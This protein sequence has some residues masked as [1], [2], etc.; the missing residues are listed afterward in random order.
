MCLQPRCH[1]VWSSEGSQEKSLRP[2]QKAMLHT[3]SPPPQHPR[4]ASQP[5]DQVSRIQPMGDRQ[6]HF[7]EMLLKMLLPLP[8]LGGFLMLFSKPIQLLV[9]NGSSQL[10]K[11]LRYSLWTV[12]TI[13]FVTPRQIHCFSFSRTEMAFKETLLWHYIYLKLLQCVVGSLN[14]CQTINMNYP[15]CIRF[16][17]YLGI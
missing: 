12:F 7:L 6:V 9:F 13:V 10:S 3:D 5:E 2:S 8:V 11:P 16:N 15:G 14:A 4:P 17:C 1:H